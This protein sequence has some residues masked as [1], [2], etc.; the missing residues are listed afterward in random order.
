[1]WLLCCAPG[2]HATLLQPRMTHPVICFPATLLLAV[3]AFWAR[4][5]AGY[6]VLLRWTVPDPQVTGYRLYAGPRSRT[7]GQPI[8]MGRLDG[9][10][11]SGIVY[12]RLQGLQPGAASYVAVTAYSLAMESDYSN[13]K[14]LNLSSVTPPPVSAGPDLTGAIGQV[15]ALG[16]NPQSGISYFWQQTA[17]PP[18]T[19]LNRTTSRA[20]FS[21]TTAGTFQFA[22]TAYDGQGVAAQ[23]VVNVVVT[24]LPAFTPTSTAIATRTPISVQ[25]RTFTPTPATHPANTPTSTSLP[26]HDADGDGIPNASDN[27][28]NDFNPAQSDIN[29][30]GIGDACDSGTPAPMTLSRVRLKAAPKALIVIQ[31]TLDATEWGS[32]GDALTGGLTV[33]VIGAGLPMPQVLTFP[34]SGCVAPSAFRVRCVGVDGETARFLKQRTRNMFKLTI[35]A[36]K[37]TFTP[38]LQP[39]SVEVMLSVGGLDRGA[40]I[41]SC[42]VRRTAKSATCRK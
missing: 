8:D 38:P 30:N 39:G 36:K 13:E 25:T 6:D 9:S 1:M 5:C 42:T 40:S 10:T 16:S 32:L 33:G 37:R 15:F 35:Y 23:D 20:Q 19:L 12:Y 27:C 14:L 17:G 4:P 26:Q 2:A 22:L 29:E 21:A 34:P 18:V 7:Y 31:A 41:D 3:V 24:T 28:P 11:L